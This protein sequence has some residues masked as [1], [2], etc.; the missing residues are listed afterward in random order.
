M[1]SNILVLLLLMSPSGINQEV[2]SEALLNIE[3]AREFV[4]NSQAAP[5]YT[6]A[7]LWAPVAE[8]KISRFYVDQRKQRVDTD[9][10]SWIAEE[11][12]SL[13]LVF[14]VKEYLHKK[15]PLSVKVYS[16]W[17]GSQNRD[18]ALIVTSLNPD[19]SKVIARTSVKIG[20]VWYTNMHIYSSHNRDS[21]MK[22]VA[23]G[24]YSDDK[25]MNIPRTVKFEFTSFHGV[26]QFVLAIS[27]KD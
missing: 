25:E 24:Y 26:K 27:H 14:N 23:V 10:K 15:I 22:A 6:Y 20:D 3:K 2:S 7:N 1:L 5:D 21:D 16:F 13:W 11:V 12:R 19:P 8:E 18:I 9:K 17:D 4:M